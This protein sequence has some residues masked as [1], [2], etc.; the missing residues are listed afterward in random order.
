VG[1]SVIVERVYLAQQDSSLAVYSEEMFAEVSQRLLDRV[2]EKEADPQSRLAFG[3]NTVEIDFDSAGRLTI[4][5]R[6]REFA[7]LT[8]DVMVAG[9]LTHVEIWDL[10]TYM[11][12]VDTLD[13]VVQ[14]QFKDGGTI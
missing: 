7:G 11:A 2:R 4:P 1:G 5:Q 6:L 3:A 10:E 8:N 14:E 12:Q 9:A 13:D